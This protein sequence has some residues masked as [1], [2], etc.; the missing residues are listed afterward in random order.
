M[1]LINSDK[2]LRIDW[3]N[4]K[5][6]PAWWI[7]FSNIYKLLGLEEKVNYKVLDEFRQMIEEIKAKKKKR[8]R[9]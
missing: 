7:G 5:K 4:V 2:C 8:K 6:Y 9:K 3:E 1:N